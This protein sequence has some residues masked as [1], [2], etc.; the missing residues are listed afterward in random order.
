MTPYLKYVISLCLGREKKT[1]GIARALQVL[2]QERAQA[3]AERFRSHRSRDIHR[4]ARGI[5]CA[6][7]QVSGHEVRRCILSQRARAQGDRLGGSR[8]C[9]LGFDG[10]GHTPGGTDALQTQIARASH[11]QEQA[12]EAQAFR[13]LI[14]YRTE[15]GAL[16]VT[17]G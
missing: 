17:S 10:L 1:E 16:P 2:W 11:A 13:K 12:A 9:H 8:A 3:A 5:R 15:L 14:R 4:R 6:R 7:F